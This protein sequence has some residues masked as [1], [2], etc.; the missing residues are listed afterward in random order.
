VSRKQ[1]IVSKIAE[2][3]KA[4]SILGGI[5][6]VVAVALTLYWALYGSRYISTDNAYP[7]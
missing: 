4:F 7:A 1:Q 3:K 2:R 5:V 6:G